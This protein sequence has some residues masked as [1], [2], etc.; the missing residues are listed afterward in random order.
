[1]TETPAP[2]VASNTTAPRRFSRLLPLLIPLLAFAAYF[3]SL[4]NSF[5]FDDH[6]AIVNNPAIRGFWPQMKQWA[7]NLRPVGTATLAL[8]YFLGGLNPVGYHLTNIAIHAAAGVVLFLL[9]R[10][11]LT[12]DSPDTPPTPRT[13]ITALAIALLWTLH[14][15]QTQAVTYTV[16]RFESLMGL[17][18]LLSLY[19][20][21]LGATANKHRWAYFI[22]MFV[23]LAL[24]LGS[25]QVIITA[26]LMILLYDRAF[27]TRSFR[28]ALR[29]RAAVY[30]ALT[31]LASAGMV[32]LMK[33]L[34]WS[35]PRATV[36]FHAAGATVSDYALAQPGVILHYLRLVFVPEPLVIDYFWPATETITAALPSL[37]GVVALAALTLFAM[38]RYPRVGFVAAWFFVI[39]APTSSFVPVN[40]RAAEHRVYLSLAGVVALVVFF[41]DWLRCKAVEAAPDRAKLA[42][43]AAIALL[44]ACATAMASLTAA[45]NLD[46]RDEVTIWADT[47]L[48]R[49][50]NPRAHRNLASALA[51]SGKLADAEIAL[52]R[53]LQLFPNDPA[54]HKALAHILMDAKRTDDAIAQFQTALKIPGNEDDAEML[55]ELASLLSLRRKHDA[56]IAALRRAV[57]LAPD[58]VDYL[59]RLGEA[60]YAAGDEAAGAATL[61]AAISRAPDDSAVR[62]SAGRALAGMGKI[63]LALPHL[64]EAVRLAP[65]DADACSTLAAALS[66]LGKTGEAIPPLRHA[67]ALRPDSP[68]LARKL[69]A[70]LATQASPSPG[71]TAEAIRLAIAA[72]KATGNIV[73]AYLDTLATAFAADGQHRQAADVVTHMIGLARKANRP[74]LLPRLESRLAEYQAKSRPASQP[75]AP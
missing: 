2:P 38:I 36:G 23:A 13:E 20:F 72:S 34:F 11:T 47:A 37:A 59:V 24:G 19:L 3:N 58:S 32:A 22:G 10:K 41:V 6:D 29:A 25:K 74:D 62:L 5:V 30:V 66:I 4:G 33:V 56:A 51:K 70:T 15:L 67:L 26:P 45:R 1:M 12:L 52:R 48:K 42:N 60:Q 69:A 73:P 61:Q 44:A 16:Q 40:D 31:I 21:I 14:P 17:F 68:E 57:Q 18:Y 49:P 54:G 39:L 64:R 65:D 63:E 9:A 53:S 75:A 50:D 71:D 8:N 35:G 28:A 43:A 55:A 46:Y 27:L 7:D